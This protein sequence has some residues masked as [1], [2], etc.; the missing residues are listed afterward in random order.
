MKV[1]IQNKVALVTGAN[2]GIGKAIV[3]TFITHG[4]RK[5]YAAVRDI[6]SATGLVATYGDKV[7]PVYVDMSKPESITALAEL[8]ADVQIVVNNAG[9]LEPADALSDNAEESL[10]KELTINTFGLI[11]IAKALSPII[12]HSGG[13]A[14]VQLNSVASIKN[15]SG[16]TTYSAS[17]AASYSITQG[18]KDELEP[19]GILVLSVHPGPIATD[20]ADKVGFSGS[21]EPTSVVSEGIVSALKA[22]DFHLFPD[23]VA[24]EF[25]SAYK[26]Y[27]ENVIEAETQEA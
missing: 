8:V 27:A 14:F 19:K 25:E 18:L 16:L 4:A 6:E 10:S 3:E 5:V 9:V 22:G 13:G 12:E 2:R 20:M 15:F 7:V 11:R 24:K 26:N 17:K 1:D 21:A 23:S